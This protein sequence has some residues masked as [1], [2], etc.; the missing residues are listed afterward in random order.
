MENY[1]QNNGVPKSTRLI[2]IL[3]GIL[4]GIIGLCIFCLFLFRV[5]EVSEAKT[6][7]II[8]ENPPVEYLAPF[9]VEHIHVL[10]REGD[11]VYKG[12][13][14]AIIESHSIYKNYTTVKH[15][16]N[17]LE[18]NIEVYDKIASNLKKKAKYLRKN[19]YNLKR[20]RKSSTQL[21]EAEQSSLLQQAQAA[22]RE[23]E[24]AKKNYE[25]DKELYKERVIAKRD[26]DQ[27]EQNYLAS[28][29]NFEVLS[30]NA[31]KE[32]I[33]KEDIDIEYVGKINEERLKSLDAEQEYLNTKK[34][35]IDL[36]KEL[37]IA[38]VNK[39]FLEEEIEHQYIKSKA[40]GFVQFLYNT[41]KEVNI[42]KKNDPLMIVTPKEKQAFYAKL[43]LSQQAAKSVKVNQ[44]VHLELDAYD[45]LKFGVTKGRVT[46]LSEGDKENKFYALVEITKPNP[47]YE[48]KNGYLVKADIILDRVPLYDFVLRR[49]FSEKPKY[50]S[51]GNQP[52]AKNKN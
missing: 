46:Y 47:N 34:K 42:F 44:T 18:D 37:K 21:N 9:D 24:I 14:L 36:K 45:V 41:K 19:K 10:V 20:R 38:I 32:G 11:F 28:R 8:A 2:K 31:M 23:F 13:T 40:D 22:K 39:R 15:E 12:D 48:L 4:L 29:R 26:F 33:K 27:T 49:L 3:F 17:M 7:E 35:I 52:Q 25:I 30:K 16:I 51:K 43:E 5:N 1:W 6:G 50:S